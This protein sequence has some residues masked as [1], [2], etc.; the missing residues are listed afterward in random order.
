MARSAMPSYGRARRA[1]APR[2][3]SRRI[4]AHTVQVRLST[5]RDAGWLK[6]NINGA[7]LSSRQAGVGIVARDSS[8]TVLFA[9][10]QSRMQ[11][12]PSRT[13]MAALADIQDYLMVDCF[14]A[15]GVIIEGD[16]LNLINIHGNRFSSQLMLGKKIIFQQNSNE[17][18]LLKDLQNKIEI[19]YEAKCRT[20]FTYSYNFVQLFLLLV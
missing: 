4:R 10:G 5:A 20:E 9:V 13:E 2:A 18:A 12:D 1:N 8:S 15:S 14:D 6:I 16:C 3:R 19:F 11:W 7:L 17:F